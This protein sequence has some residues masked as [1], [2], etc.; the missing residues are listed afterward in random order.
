MSQPHPA[1]AG[2]SE[3]W[4]NPASASPADI[5]RQARPLPPVEETVI[6][7]LTED[8]ERAFWEAIT[9]A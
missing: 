8:E 4:D 6:D 1:A 9:T 7:D 3:S 5:L 2:G